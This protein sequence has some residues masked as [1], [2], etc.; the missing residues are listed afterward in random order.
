[1]VFR[2]T[3]QID[4]CYGHRLINHAGKCRY[5]HG[6]NGRVVISVACEELDGRGMVFDFTD[7][8][9]EVG[10]WIDANLDHCMLLC[11]EDPAIPVLRELGEPI[12]VIPHNPTAENIARLIAEVAMDRG[13]PVESVQLWE[14]PRCCAA[15]EVQRE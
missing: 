7:M 3:C 9:R 2:A 12:F 14:T 13:F 15:Y 1:M 5:L 10:G 4:F 11:E 6:H 8:K